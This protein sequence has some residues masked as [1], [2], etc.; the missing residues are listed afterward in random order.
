MSS[1][2]QYKNDSFISLEEF[3]TTIPGK[4]TFTTLV[5]LSILLYV[6]IGLKIFT[7]VYAGVQVW[8]MGAGADFLNSLVPG[9]V[10]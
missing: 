10:G 1:L 3:L 5:V 4:A 6:W 2:D 8:V 7:W 9:L